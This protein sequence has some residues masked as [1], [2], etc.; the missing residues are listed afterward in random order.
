MPI[1]LYGVD[2]LQLLSLVVF[3]FLWLKIKNHYFALFG[4]LFHEIRNGN[5]RV[6]TGFFIPGP[7]PW[8]RLDP[9]TKRIFSRGS[10]PF[11]SGPVK[12][13]QK[14]S[15]F[16]FFF[17]FEGKLFWN[18]PQTQHQTHGQTTNPKNPFFSNLHS[19]TQIKKNKKIKNPFFNPQTQK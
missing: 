8:P 18:K 19:N 7:D 9:F 1:L 5:G 15:F 14:G 10:N 3:P 13:N 16:F 11:P 6:R 2:L 12:P 4:K 17:I